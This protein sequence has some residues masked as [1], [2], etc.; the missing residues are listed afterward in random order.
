G[1]VRSAISVSRVTIA[2]A[3]RTVAMFGDIRANAYAV[4]AQT[5]ELVWKTKV[6][7][8][9]F[10]RVTG[11]P[12]FA[13]GRLYVPVSSFEEGPGARA[14]Y[15]CCTF[16]GSVVALDG[17]TGAQV[18]KSYMIPE[19]PKIVGKN[20]PGPPCGKPPAAPRL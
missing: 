16:R 18:W 13:N 20:S 19:P 12:A 10:A 1:G 6:D 2:N 7:D 15:Q 14:N 3:P 4:D 5:G 11:A 9:A 8:H 17:A